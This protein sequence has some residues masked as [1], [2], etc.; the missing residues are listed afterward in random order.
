MLTTLSSASKKIVGYGKFFLKAWV[1]E[2]DDFMTVNLGTGRGYSVL[3]VV[4]AFEKASGR[5]VP[6]DMQPR[7]AGDVATC[8]A[9]TDLAAKVLGGWRA[10][11]DMQTMC[12]D[13]WR[14]QSQNPNGYDG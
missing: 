13:H 2:T 11:R 14:W 8:Y 3:D 12:R 6:Y 10:T 9:A 5:P 4:K 7:R 1:R